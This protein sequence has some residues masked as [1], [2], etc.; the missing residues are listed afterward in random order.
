MEKENMN[1]FLKKI[2]VAKNP[3]LLK[4]ELSD[5]ES[6]DDNDFEIPEFLLKTGYLDS[7]LILF[8]HYYPKIVKIFE[9]GFCRETEYLLN[10]DKYARKHPYSVLKYLEKSDNKNIRKVIKKIKRHEGMTYE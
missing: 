10:N 6:F 4:K 3:F 1:F 9:Y 2:D 8:K 5:G 7:F